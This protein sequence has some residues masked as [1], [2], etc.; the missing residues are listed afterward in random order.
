MY[1]CLRS[2]ETRRKSRVHKKIVDRVFSAL[3]QDFTR[4]TDIQLPTIAYGHA[5]LAD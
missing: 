2:S 4:E 5:E 3:E 1:H